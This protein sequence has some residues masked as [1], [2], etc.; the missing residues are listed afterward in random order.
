MIDEFDVSSTHRLQPITMVKLGIIGIYALIAYIVLALYIRNKSNKKLCV[1]ILIIVQFI[2]E[3]LGALH[4]FAINMPTTMYSAIIGIPMTIIEI[5][6][7]I[8]A[9]K[10]K[11]YKVV[12]SILVICSIIVLFLMLLTGLPKR[13]K[14]LVWSE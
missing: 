13:I 8:I 12:F 9:L 6:L 5:V 7:C 2:A 10:N 3:V 11:K 14:Y 4:S 1:N